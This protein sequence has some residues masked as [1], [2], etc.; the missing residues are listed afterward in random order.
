MAIEYS[1]VIFLIEK[2]KILL[3]NPF[4]FLFLLKKLEQTSENGGGI[5][6]KIFIAGRQSPENQ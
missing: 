2:W 5:R 6:E 3:K 1:M 4:F